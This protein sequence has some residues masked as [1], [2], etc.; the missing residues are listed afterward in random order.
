MPPPP[1]GPDLCLAEAGRRRPASRRTA[2]PRPAR[3]RAA[4]GSRPACGSGSGHGAAAPRGLGEA[5]FPAP[6][7]LAAQAA[8]PADPAD[9]EAPFAEVPDSSL[10][11]E[12]DLD[13]PSAA[14]GAAPSAGKPAPAAEPV[15]DLPPMP[16]GAILAAFSSRRAAGDPAPAAP[17]AGG[18]EGAAPALPAARRSEA[19]RPDAAALARA[20][21]GKPIEDLP[22][23]PRPPQAG[24]RP[25]AAAGGAKSVARGLGA[26]V[27]S[28]AMAGGRKGGKG[29]PAV[30]AP[31]AAAAVAASAALPSAAA[32]AAAPGEAARSLGRSPFAGRPAPK[33]SP[34]VFLILVAI[35]LL[36]LAAVAAWSSFWLAS[37]DDPAAVEVAAG[38][39][40]MCLRSRTR[41]PPMRWTP[42]RWPMASPRKRA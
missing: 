4:G 19:P 28:P 25:G 8:R 6:A 18:A 17:A 30:P 7:P 13:P 42:R 33:R 36:A 5:D 37:R 29:K 10:F 40:P 15:D 24:S 22:P 14:P 2:G 16:A 31:S 38:W 12:D 9:E 1:S 23:M 35:L 21:R 11:P 41:W 27:G 3:R 26:L 32:V 39:P 34:F 20:A